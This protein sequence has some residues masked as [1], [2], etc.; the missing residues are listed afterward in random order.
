MQKYK[1][2]EK[3]MQSN[4]RNLPDLWPE[5]DDCCGCS[6]C[7]ATCPKSA[8]SMEADEEG[9]LYPVIDVS[10]CIRCGK[11]LS[12]CVFKKDKKVRWGGAHV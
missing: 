2:Q 4:E 10:K 8:I 3:S 11:C 5:K 12:V 9:F 7:Y 6:A 1:N